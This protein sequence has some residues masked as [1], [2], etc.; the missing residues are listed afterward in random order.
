MASRSTLLRLP[1][2]ALLAAASLAAP[3]RLAATSV[4]LGTDAELAD[5]APVVVEATVI[6]QE[7]PAFTSGLP[8]T[9]YRLRVERVLKGRVAG[10][11]LRLRVLGGPGPDGLTLKIWGAPDLSAGE[12]LLLFL[13]ADADGS[14]RPV[15][16]AVGVFH[17]VAAAGPDGQPVAVRDLSEMEVV[18]AR[19]GFTPGTVQVRDYARFVEWLADRAGGQER[20]PDYQLELPA[21]DFRQ[22]QEKFNYLGG[23]KQRWFEFDSGTAVHWTMYEAGQP[24]LADLGFNEFQ[25]AMQAWNSNPGTDI[26]YVYDGTSSFT[27]GFQHP[28]GH[29]TLLPGDPNDD[30][31]GSFTCT[32]PG[33][34]NGIL[35]AGGTWFPTNAAPPLPIR[36]A[37]I[38][39]QDGA[40]C[41]FNDDPAR[42][43]Q[44]F[45]HELGHSLGLGH[46]CGDSLTGSCNTPEKDGAL[47]RA[48]AHNDNRGAT[49]GDDDRA[50]IATLYGTGTGSGGGGSPPAAPSLLTATA[51]SASAIALAWKDNGSGATQIDVER[52]APGGRFHQIQ[53]LPGGTRSSTVTGLAAGLAY[54]FRVRAHNSA[55]Y[56]DYS[57]A[58]GATTRGNPM[59]AP[60]GQT[61]AP[62]VQ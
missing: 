8:T 15:H 45:A 20:A 4:V 29:N 25:V 1:V 54:S 3:R 40:G 14:Y 41:W 55:G 19:G 33:N 6:A 44:V 42:A 43:E 37:D 13:V 12:T 39:L 53:T 58:A 23:L 11:S 24:G 59:P 61:S 31:P 35:G 57:N 5:Q 22:V 10:S 51:T 38:V 50:G 9:D 36:E 18:D 26:R 48:V 32:S 16:L 34:G 30:L 27:A 60:A 56:S 47:M 21:A 62:D 52:K 7:P 28:D 49:L 2:L 46:S 17:Q